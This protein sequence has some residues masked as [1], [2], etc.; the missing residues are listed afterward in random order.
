MTAPFV[1]GTSLRGRV[2][3]IDGDEAILEPLLED[4]TA[5]GLTVLNVHH[6]VTASYTDDD[7]PIPSGDAEPELPADEPDLLT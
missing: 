5:G 7:L 6:V 4:G 1:D 3:E 2:L